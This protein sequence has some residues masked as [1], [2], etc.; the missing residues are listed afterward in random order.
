[1]TA[2]PADDAVAD[3]RAAQIVEALRAA[4]WRIA[5]AESLT[6]GALCA[7]LTAVPGASAVV[8]GG[9]VSYATQ[10]KAEILGVD[11]ALLEQVG[12]VDARVAA[13][14]AQGVRQLLGAEVGIATTGSAGP[15]PA[16][17]GTR[18][19]PVPAGT[20]FIAL[21]TPAGVWRAALGDVAAPGDPDLA[22]R[23]RAPGEHADPVATR[24]AIRRAVVAAALDLA[25]D[26]LR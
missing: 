21:A 25:L 24:A 3:P 23:T 14:M 8:L 13:E 12:A 10:V 19:A 20:A 17:G 16:P 26:G 6:G 7:T 9:V 4:G 1:M 11:R 2:A 18:R 22:S 15:D 5:T